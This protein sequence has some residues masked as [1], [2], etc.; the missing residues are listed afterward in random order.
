[1]SDHFDTVVV[2]AGSAG[3]VI[4]SRL[5]EDARRRVLLV[6]AGPDFARDSLPAAV[7]DATCPT[8][9][10][11]WGYQ[12]EPKGP[13]SSIGLPRAKLVGG[14]SA[15]N[16]TFAL[17]GSPTDYDAWAA[18]GNDGWSFAEV[19]PYFCKLETDHDFGGDWHGKAGPIAIRRARRDELRPHQHAAIEAALALGHAVVDDHNRPHALGAGPTPRNVDNG[20]RQ[21]TA[22]AYVE[23]AR[24]RENFTLRAGTLVD[25]VIVTDGRARG[26]RLRGGG[27]VTGDAIV[28]AAGAYGSP[29]LLLRSGIG[30]SSDLRSLDI[31]VVVDLPGVG[32]NLIDHPALSVD[33]GVAPSATGDWFQTVMTWRSEHAGTDPYDMHLVPGGPINDVF[34]VFVGLMRPRSRGRVGL[35]SR[36]ADAPPGIRLG[37]LDAAEDLSRMI[38]GVRHARELLHTSPLRELITGPELK[39]GL[40]A[41]DD[42]D[43][44][45]A[46]RRELSVYHHACGTCAM[47][48]RPEDGAVVDNHGRVHGI[49]GLIIADA[50]IMPMIPAA[51]TNL[52]VMMIGERI[53]ATMTA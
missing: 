36:D 34:F 25:H 9:D 15:T 31:D 6:E 21:S 27:A 35:R 1:V 7:A 45:H 42:G 22:I 14:C 30:P 46:I 17:R 3:A 19:L 50:S 52:P 41:S 44:A 33:V 32:A 29:A 13:A 12:S 24:R 47:G 48:T 40:D 5:S 49:E 38:E 10:F 23:P 51:N 2:G 53:A 8:T 18:A 43:L 16:A 39:L 37:G 20:V 11:D 26:V 28:L 4:A